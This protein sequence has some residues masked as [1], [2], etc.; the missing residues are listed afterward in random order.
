MDEMT[1]AQHIASKFR[2]GMARA[3]VVVDE[4]VNYLADPLRKY[5]NFRVVV[6]MAGMSD[7][8]IKNNLLG[9][10]ILITNNTKD[11][12]NDASSYDYGIISLEKLKYIDPTDSAK[13]ITCKLISDAVV[14]NDLI[15][16]GSNFICVLSP[17]GKHSLKHI[18]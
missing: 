15:S 4:N 11:F 13:N 9:H 12:I 3:T 10:R 2:S 1:V 16:I 18:E 8:Y 17:D 6:P 14:E 5:H 7:E